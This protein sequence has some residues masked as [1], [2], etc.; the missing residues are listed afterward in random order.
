MCNAC[1]MENIKADVNSRRSFFTKAAA[2][3]CGDGC[4]KGFF[5]AIFRQGRG[6]DA[7]F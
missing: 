5:G 1:L 2:A 3:G 4:F 7:Y 6:P